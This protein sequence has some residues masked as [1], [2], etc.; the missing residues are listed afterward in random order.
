MSAARSRRG[1]SPLATDLPPVEK[2]E[3]LGDDPAVGE[4]R[5]QLPAGAVLLLFVV[6]MAVAASGHWRRG[7][8]GLGAAALAGGIARWALPTRWA[9]M[10]AVRKRWFDVGLM[11]GT[12]AIVWL[13]ALVVPPQ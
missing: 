12:G 4:R 13:V 2:I 3:P 1:P 7:A 6:G 11:L 9:G 5:L 8:F 10:L